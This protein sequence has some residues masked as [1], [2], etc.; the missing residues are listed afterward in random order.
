MTV[1]NWNRCAQT[2]FDIMVGRCGGCRLCRW[3]AVLPLPALLQRRSR[4]DMHGCSAWLHGAMPSPRHTC[5]PPRH[6]PS[7]LPV[8]PQALLSD[9]RQISLTDSPPE[10]ERQEEPE[11]GA[12]TLVWGNLGAF[13]ERL[14]DEWNGSLKVGGNAGAFCLPCAGATRCALCCC[15]AGGSTYTS[16]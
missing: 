9:N 10:E 2:M 7:H 3:H 1:P 12:P 8:L 4:G 14:D 16:E 6:H 5:T 11:A 15:N 13:L